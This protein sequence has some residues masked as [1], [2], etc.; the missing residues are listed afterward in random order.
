MRRPPPSPVSDIH[1]WGA[2]PAAG[3]TAPDAAS[4]SEEVPPGYAG[5]A[6]GMD[7]G[8]AAEI[9]LEHIDLLDTAA[10]GRRDGKFGLDDM[11]A[12][13][14]DPNAP[15][16]LRDAVQYVLADPTALNALDV[17]GGKK[18][19]RVF[20]EKD[21]KRV[22]SEDRD[23]RD[24][25]GLEKIADTLLHRKDGVYDYFEQL[26]GAKNGELWASAAGWAFARVDQERL[27]VG[28][29]ECGPDDADQM[30]RA[31]VDLAQ[32]TGTERIHLPV[33]AVDW[34]VAALEASQF[35]LHPMVIY[36][37]AL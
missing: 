30:I 28:W 32:D 7:L 2:R 23:A 6:E 12:I 37:R 22:I 29:L 17:A 18:V 35:E 16:E 24:I 4:A 13:A 26:D 1:P 33:P 10:G 34:L 15:Q 21:L 3:P 27:T 11:H 14:A 5:D 20:S 8:S 31:I 25:M 9:M 36:E 19:D